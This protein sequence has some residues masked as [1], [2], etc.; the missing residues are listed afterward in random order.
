[1]ARVCIMQIVPSSVPLGT[2]NAAVSGGMGCVSRVLLSPYAGFQIPAIRRNTAFLPKTG[3]SLR[4]SLSLQGRTSEKCRHPMITAL[5]DDSAGKNG[6]ANCGN[7]KAAFETLDVIHEEDARPAV[8]DRTS[9][10]SSAGQPSMSFAGDQRD[11]RGVFP[12]IVP[13]VSN[14]TQNLTGNENSSKGPTSGSVTLFSGHDKSVF[15]NSSDYDPTK[16]R[17]ASPVENGGSVDGDERNERYFKESEKPSF[18][19]LVWEAGAKIEGVTTDVRQEENEPN[20]QSLSLI[21]D[22]DYRA[23]KKLMALEEI[24]ATFPNSEDELNSREVELLAYTE[25]LLTQAK[26]NQ[27]AYAS[28]QE[29]L[30][31][32]EEMVFHLQTQVDELKED[33]VSRDNLLRL[34]QKEGTLSSQSLQ[35]AAQ[36]LQDAEKKMVELERR[37]HVGEDLLYKER[38]KLTAALRTAGLHEHAL[39]IAELKV[40]ELTA[41]VTSLKESLGT[42]KGVEQLTAQVKTLEQE[43]R[44]RDRLLLE[45]KEETLRS[46]E[47]LKLAAQIK[48]DLNAT[49]QREIHLTQTLE[50]AN[51]KIKELEGQLAHNVRATRAEGILKQSQK[52]L[53]EVKSEVEL[54]RQGV[55]ARD[56]AINIMKDEVDT[57]IDLLRS[58]ARNRE[59]LRN[60]N[61]HV[62][63][64]RME[65]ESR[66]AKLSMMREEMALII[67]LA[68]KQQSPRKSRSKT[69]AQSPAT[70]TSSSS[71]VDVEELKPKRKTPVR[72]SRESGTSSS[73]A[74]KPNGTRR[75]TRSPP[76]L[77]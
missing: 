9:V 39:K 36:S 46:T 70:S 55:E 6:S 11:V 58:A 77:P 27:E 29:A 24:L 53:S 35:R 20:E 32:A 44:S 30:S 16:T 49:R 74:R 23:R 12:S 18:V 38:D 8:D 47:A 76:Q 4:T 51:E 37:V 19:S 59:E 1:M 48:Q 60:M 57:N 26:M 73:P 14:N 68:K 28:S 50:A 43:L 67:D 25:K 31:T 33:V 45:I 34:L 7:G 66:D 71:P 75:T 21:I 56:R 64:L 40:A 2:E 13:S 65:L 63:E 72:K 17:R 3:V 61:R 15:L 22:E 42:G 52:M 62:G 41:E 69:I 5:S 10:D 54:L